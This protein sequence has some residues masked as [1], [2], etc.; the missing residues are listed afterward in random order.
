[1]RFLP[2]VGRLGHCR[3][4]SWGHGTWRGVPRPHA[5][6]SLIWPHSELTCL[7]G[8]LYLIWASDG[9]WPFLQ[10]CKG[11]HTSSGFGRKNERDVSTPCPFA[12]FASNLCGCAGR[13]FDHFWVG[14]EAKTFRSPLGQGTSICDPCVLHSHTSV[15]RHLPERRTRRQHQHNKASWPS[16]QCRRPVRSK[17]CF[18]QLACTFLL[19]KFVRDRTQQMCRGTW[20]CKPIQRSKGKLNW[21]D[22]LFHDKGKLSTKRSHIYRK[23]TGFQDKKGFAVCFLS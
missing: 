7:I 5:G 2:D 16:T 6:L 21:S 18:S 17:F 3:H 14:K 23:A 12:P 8:P 20:L 11:R 4:V 15:A 9:T 13:S 10:V 19:C 22:E 1:M